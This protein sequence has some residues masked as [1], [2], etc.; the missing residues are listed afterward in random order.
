MGDT[1]TNGYPFPVGTDRVMDGDNAIEALAEA[2]DADSQF[3][4]ARA[5]GQSIAATT[6]TGIAWQPASENGCALNKPDG[7]TFTA[8]AA[9][10]YL[11]S[12]TVSI[13]P[14][15]TGRAF[16]DLYV[17]TTTAGRAIFSGDGKCVVTLVNRLIPGDSIRAEV[18][19]TTADT[20]DAGDAVLNVTRVGRSTIGTRPA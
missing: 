3:T 17:G 13:S 1:T 8:P 14:A 7:Y 11:A 12:V 6:P 16:L 9:G 10:I 2:V 19:L 4:H 5:V 15:Q 20:L 18:Y